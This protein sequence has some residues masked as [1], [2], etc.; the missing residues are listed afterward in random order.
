VTEVER[1]AEERKN[2][3]VKIDRKGETERFRE[4]EREREREEGREK[5]IKRY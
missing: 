2:W 5:K 3:D 1:Q 4:G